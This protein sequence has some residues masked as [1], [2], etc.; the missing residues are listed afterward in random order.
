MCLNVVYSTDDNYAIHAGVSIVSL[1]ENN[2]D[3]ELINI[4]IIDN[5]ITDHNKETL[6]TIARKYSNCN[7]CFLDF[8]NYIGKLKLNMQWHISISSYARLFLESLLPNDIKKVLYLD[9][10]TI[11]NS[12]LKK[13]W[14][15]NIEDYYF[16]GVQDSVNS[17]TKTAIGITTD[18]RYF[19]AGIL[20]IN[21]DLWRK[22]SFEKQF[23]NFI[24][25]RNGNVI[26]HDQGVINGVLGKNALRLPLENNLMT[27]HYFMNRKKILKFF[28]EEA[29]FYS[30]SEIG[31]AI[32]H[33]VI[34]HFT[35]SFTSRP[36][37]KGCKHPKKNLYFEYLN[38]TPWKGMKPLKDNSKWYI[39][40][41]NWRYR[42]LYR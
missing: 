16:A 25:E 12:S 38:L 19:N 32:N 17:N 9:C 21:L 29:D 23:I 1:L 33:P 7:I 15:T 37:I 5:Q 36:W 2:K 41:I 3:F 31:E 39:K 24:D 20:L 42:T 35:P 6:Y 13:L 27:I 18:K 4:Y 40:L 8:T 10:D 14:S 30:E 26:H 28:N 34:Y 22:N 11:I